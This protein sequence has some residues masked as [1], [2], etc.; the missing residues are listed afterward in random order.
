MLRIR[1]WDK[2]FEN[3]AS[4]KLKRLDWVAI[5][6]KTCGEGYV[7]L[8]DHENGAAHL[9]AWYA[10]VE[11]ASK[12]ST[13]GILP[14]GIP[15]TLAGICRSLGRMSRLPAD[16]FHEAIP[17]LLEIGWLEEVVANQ[18]PAASSADS[19]TTSAD[20]PDA[21]ADSPAIVA[22][23]GIELQG[24]EPKGSTSNDRTAPPGAPIQFGDFPL[25]AAAVRRRFATADVVIVT[26]IVEACAAAFASVDNP[27]IETPGD[28]EFA[29]AIERAAEET[30]DQLSPA[31]FLRTA[32][33]VM[34]SWARYG[35][36]S[37]RATNARQAGIDAEWEAIGNGT[38]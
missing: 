5:P 14:A 10:I 8:V 19:P 34:E 3:A 21:S 36:E 1:D 15:P 35:R 6:N 7:A 4:R 38:R 20:S 11:A 32:P 26:R 12:Q 29:A 2:H 27:V 37:K 33:A 31:L 30:K 25:S 23:Q 18:Q 13:R 9:G 16:V 17:R 28:S 22:L 24:I